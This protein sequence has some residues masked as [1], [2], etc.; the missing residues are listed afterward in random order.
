MNKSSEGQ[1]NTV[2]FVCDSGMSCT[3]VRNYVHILL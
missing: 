3:S 2:V 1:N